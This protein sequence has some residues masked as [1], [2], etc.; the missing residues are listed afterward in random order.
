[1]RNSEFLSFAEQ[2]IYS[3]KFNLYYFFFS[4][5]SV[6]GTRVDSLPRAFLRS[7]RVSKK[8]KKI[9]QCQNVSVVARDGN[10]DSLL[11]LAEFRKEGPTPER[12]RVPSA[13]EGMG[14]GRR[15]HTPTPEGYHPRTWR[16]KIKILSKKNN[17]KK[18]PLEGI[19][20]IIGLAYGDLS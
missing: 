20:I 9:R 15:R 7:P 18:Q 19:I 13:R 11:T 6:V 10:D 14:D 17:K 1:M 4:Y 5:F 2:S 8:T 3:P 16:K 12:A